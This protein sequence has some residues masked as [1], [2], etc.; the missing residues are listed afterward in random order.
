MVSDKST[1]F[2]TTWQTASY[3]K[4]L[5]TEAGNSGDITHCAEYHRLQVDN[6]GSDGAVFRGLIMLVRLFS[7]IALRDYLIHR[8]LKAREELRLKSCISREIALNS[9]II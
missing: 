9:K 2:E 7:G 6:A 3:I 8:F 1:V 4:T 5:E